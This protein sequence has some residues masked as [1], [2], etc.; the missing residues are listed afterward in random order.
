MTVQKRFIAGAIC[1]RCADVD[2][3]RIRVELATFQ[4]Q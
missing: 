1:P 3:Q 2:E 4:C